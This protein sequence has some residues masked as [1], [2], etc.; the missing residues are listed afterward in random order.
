MPTIKAAKSA[1]R[2]VCWARQRIGF[3]SSPLI[4]GR[5]ICSCH[6]TNV[7]LPQNAVANPL[8]NTIRQRRRPQA[9]QT[10]PSLRMQYQCAWYDILFGQHRS[11]TIPSFLPSFHPPSGSY[12]WYR[13]RGI[14]NSRRMYHA[15]C[16]VSH[17]CHAAVLIS[18]IMGHARLSV[19][20]VVY[21]LLTSK[22]D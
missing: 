3:F 17:H 9:D 10:K 20:H 14:V 4:C 16:T 18:R 1:Q 5:C 12:D 13:F 2:S 8:T 22:M 15:I 19:Y 7:V 11:P 6:S 21:E